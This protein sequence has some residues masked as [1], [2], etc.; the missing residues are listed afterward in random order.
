MSSASYQLVH[1]NI[2]ETLASFDHPTM[3]DFVNRIDEIDS[4]AQATPGFVAHPTLPDEGTVFI[5][6]TL[7]N[8]SIWESIE[9]LFDFTYR[10]EHEQVFNQRAKWFKSHTQ[11]NYV[12]FWVPAGYIPTEQEVK[13]RLDYLT[14]H[15]PTP[16]AF[17]FRTRFTVEQM[18]AFEVD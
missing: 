14:Q 17:T 10:G 16:Y 3:S 13:G 7:V 5:G 2:A 12:I 6:D 1:V 4:L 11:P 8:L 18:L 9:S 15:G